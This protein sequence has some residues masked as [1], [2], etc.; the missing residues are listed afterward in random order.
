MPFAKTLYIYI[1]LQCGM[2]STTSRGQVVLKGIKEKKLR[3]TSNEEEGSLRSFGVEARV[4]SNVFTADPVVH[5]LDISNFDATVGNGSTWLVKFYAP[6]CKKS[7]ALQPVIE[8]ISTFLSKDPDLDAH[9]GRVNADQEVALSYRFYVHVKRMP[10]IYVITPQ[11]RTH[12]FNESSKREDIL[13]F[14]LGGHEDKWSMHSFANPMTWPWVLLF[15][16]LSWLTVEYGHMEALFIT[17]VSML[18]L[19]CVVLLVTFHF[20]CEIALY[21]AIRH[22]ERNAKRKVKKD[23]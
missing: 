2:F 8:E 20:I 21:Y 22:I 13:D 19:L 12:F 5:E 7:I 3:A 10:Y 18:V 4:E 16:P 15:V 11:G 23:K 17:Y 14:L 9:V 1:L 6:W